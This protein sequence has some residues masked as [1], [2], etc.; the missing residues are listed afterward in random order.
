MGN[1]GHILFKQLRSGQE[2]FS[3]MISVD[4]ILAK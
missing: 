4:A 1:D 2:K 3:G